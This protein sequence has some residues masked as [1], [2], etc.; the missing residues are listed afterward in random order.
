[1]SEGNFWLRGNFLVKE[2]FWLKESFLVEGNFW[3]GKI[4]GFKRNF[5]IEGK[6]FGCDDIFGF[7]S[8]NKK[9]I[10]ITE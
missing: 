3:L 1:M 8:I 4:F 10:K 6:F 9:N 2:N 7:K 5:L